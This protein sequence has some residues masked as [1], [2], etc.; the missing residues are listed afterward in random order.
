MTLKQT[1]IIIAP[2]RTPGPARIIIFTIDFLN[3]CQSQ[4]KACII[5]VI[6]RLKYKNRN[7]SC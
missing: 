3:T 5:K 4:L 7:E 2:I 1:P 6:T